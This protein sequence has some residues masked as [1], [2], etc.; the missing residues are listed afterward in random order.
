MAIEELNKVIS[1]PDE[2]L[3]F[4]RNTEEDTVVFVTQGQISAI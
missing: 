3:V 4:E 1:E 2:V